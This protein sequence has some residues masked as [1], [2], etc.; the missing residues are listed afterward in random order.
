MNYYG[1]NGLLHLQKI[2]FLCS[3]KVP[4]EIVLKTYDWA[5]KQR[6]KSICVISGFHSKIEKFITV[7]NLMNC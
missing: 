7:R 4:L 3:R 6:E 2:G 5:I 1:N